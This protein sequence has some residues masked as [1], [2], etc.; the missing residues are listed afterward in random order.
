MTT[1]RMDYDL[2]DVIL[3]NAFS[4]AFKQELN[5]YEA[6]AKGFSD[7]APTKQHKKSARKAYHRNQRKAFGYTTIIQRGIVSL[8][9]LFSIWN[10]MMLCSPAVQAAVKGTVTE[11]FDKYI[12][13]RFSKENSVLSVG[14]HKFGYLP[15]GYELSESRGSN[16]YEKFVFKNGNDEISLRMMA[17]SIT[18]VGIDGE[19]RTMQ[20]LAIKDYAAYAL[21]PEDTSEPTIVIWGN[22]SC[23]YV[24]SGHLEFSELVNMA[25]SIS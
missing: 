19:N 6:S 11:F 20:P 18:E 9:I 13:F 16:G 4:K 14:T 7:A 22:E 10:A 3:E 12:S 25:G 15:D 8:L 17:S 21:I 5:E 23:S 2:F 24:L 1:K